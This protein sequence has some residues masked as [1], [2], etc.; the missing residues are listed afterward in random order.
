VNIPGEERP[1]MILEKGIAYAVTTRVRKQVSC[2][3]T[4]CS[5]GVL[6]LKLVLFGVVTNMR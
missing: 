5:N 1:G 3:S 2:S 4:S 6:L